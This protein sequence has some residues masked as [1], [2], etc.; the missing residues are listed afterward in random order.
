MNRP[1]RARR[2]TFGVKEF[3]HNGSSRTMGVPAS[4]QEFHGCL[5]YLAV[6]P[7][8]VPCARHFAIARPIRM[9]EGADVSE[10]AHLPSKSTSQREILA[11]RHPNTR[12]QRS[13]GGSVHGLPTKHGNA[14]PV[15]VQSD[16]TRGGS[17]RGRAPGARGISRSSAKAP[18]RP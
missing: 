4:T 18:N 3:P 8:I 11:V 5:H 12:R 6:S 16:S 2:R 15:S 13:F 17:R 1:P 9:L 10:N 7:A 14:R